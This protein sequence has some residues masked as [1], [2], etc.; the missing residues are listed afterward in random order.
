MKEIRSSR[1]ISIGGTDR[2]ETVLRVTILRRG[3]DSINVFL[4]TS[5]SFRT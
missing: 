1:N 2:K 3:R 4:L 5:E